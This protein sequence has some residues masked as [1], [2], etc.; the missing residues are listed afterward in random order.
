MREPNYPTVRIGSWG[1]CHDGM[2]WIL[3]SYGEKEKHLKEG[4]VPS[5]IVKR[6]TYYGK[7]DSMVRA[8]NE[9][10]MAKIHLECSDLMQIA[11]RGIAN[12]VS[13]IKKVN[14]YEKS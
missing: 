7:F 10:E 5:E 1:I 11:K 2:Q 3:T 6:I 8:M 14:I 9:G 4:E 13:E 12:L